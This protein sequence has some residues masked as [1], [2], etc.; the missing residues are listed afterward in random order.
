MLQANNTEQIGLFILPSSRIHVYWDIFNLF[1]TM[2]YSISSPIRFALFFRQ[3]S[4]HTAHDPSF[5][6]DYII[7]ALY[8]FD[9]LLRLEIYAF[10]DFENGRNEVITERSMIRKNYMQSK[11]FKVDRIAIVPFDILSFIFGHH[12]LLRCNKLVRVLQISKVV[13]RLQRNFDDC[14]QVT[15]TE[16]QA[17]S[18]IML[19]YSILIIVWSSAGW[20]ALR[21][22]EGAYKSIYWALTTLTTVGYG[23]LTPIDFRETCYAIVVGAIGATFTAGIIANVTSY[24]HDTDV[25]EDNIDHKLNCVRVRKTSV[26]LM[27][28]LR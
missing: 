6:V 18:L 14:M 7:D 20:N 9:V 23:D 2:Y 12:T 27:L 3:R 8:I 26:S 1:S 10:I 5:I 11:W 17:S 25:S 16:S 19:L 28:V 21:D 4:L 13:K 15:M 22:D 24:F